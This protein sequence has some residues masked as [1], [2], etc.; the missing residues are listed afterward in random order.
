M[1]RFEDRSGFTLIEL[2]IVVAIIAILSVIAI[3]NFGEVQTRAKVAATKANLR[4]VAMS[5]EMQHVD[6][7]KYPVF[8]KWRW[9]LLH[10]DEETTAAYDD[11]EHPFFKANSQ[12]YGPFDD[13]FEKGVLQKLGLLDEA[14]LPHIHGHYLC[15]GF[16]LFIPSM[17]AAGCCPCPPPSGP[18]TLEWEGQNCRA[19]SAVHGL[20][21]AWMLYSP[22]PDLTAETPAWVNACGAEIF[23]KD[24][25]GYTDEGLFTEYDPTNGTISYGNIFRTQKNA[26]G[27][28][29]RGV[30]Q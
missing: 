29:Y 17:M 26:A 25:E 16:G 24:P 7:D 15:H 10:N 14:W 11:P 30:Y 8:G 19:W 22:G 20:A 3:P 18:P 28:G 27:L 12:I 9:F 4:T 5:I 2:L 21:G 6:T 23:R 1:K 13:P